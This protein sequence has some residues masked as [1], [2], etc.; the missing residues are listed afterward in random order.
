[1]KRALYI[2]VL[3]GCS[4][5][6]SLTQDYEG[7]G[8]CAAYV[9]AGDTHTCA[10]KTNGG[11]WCWGDNRFGQLGTGDTQQHLT[12]ARI[13]V[14]GQGATKIF[15]PAGD[16]EIS[17]DN[18][19]FTCAIVTDGSMWCWGDN[20]FGQLGL[21][22]TQ[23]RLSP[24][25]IDA[26]GTTV[27]KGGNG[28]G[29][30]CALT[31]DGAVLCWGRNIN[32]QLGTGTLSPSQVPIALD[33]GQPPFDRIYLGGRHTCARSN[34]GVLW[35]WG[36]NERGQLGVGDNQDRP[37]PTALAPLDAGVVRASAGA[38]HSCLY[39]DDGTVYCFGDNGFAELGTGDM[40]GRSL[41]IAVGLDVS[42]HVSQIFAGT[43][44]TCGISVDGSLWCWGGNRF[45]QLGMGDTQTRPTP[46]RVDALGNDV[47]V[48]YAGGAHT[49]AIKTDG[50]LWCWGNNAYGQLGTGDTKQRESPTRIMP[51]CTAP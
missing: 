12:P 14:G 43:T 15:V 35:C 31:A 26:L 2:A 28:A 25:R 20:R 8:V 44:H 29:H 19:V 30:T 40:Q 49:C 39:V 17:S 23:G 5:W 32:G 34:D 41:P 46:T 50:S 1:V 16:G 13:D 51:G 22:D 6:A 38:Q 9:V 11:F 47:S 24:T 21:G 48:A 3:A 18:S 42:L 36:A 33:A 27:A 4:D 37:K 10:R 7:S 45:G